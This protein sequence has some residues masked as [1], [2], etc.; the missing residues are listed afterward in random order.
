MDGPSP[1][2]DRNFLA[3]SSFLAVVGFSTGVPRGH[4]IAEIGPVLVFLVLVL[5][6]P[7]RVTKAV[8]VSLALVTCSAV[9]V[10][11]TNG[12]IESHFHFFV[13]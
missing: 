1:A 12:L 4:L 10:H 3:S 8:L 6:S 9:L 13:V 7:R 5:S 11:F 2:V